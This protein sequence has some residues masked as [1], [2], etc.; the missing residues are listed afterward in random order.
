M[1]SITGHNWEVI[2]GNARQSLQSIPSDSVQCCVT[3]PP[4]FGQRDYSTAHQVWGGDLFCDHEWGDEIKIDTR[5]LQTDASGIQKYP[6][7]L[8]GP[9]WPD[10]RGKAR[11]NFCRCG[12][13]QGEFGT[14]PTPQLYTEHLVEIFREVR[15]VLRPDG[16]VFLN[17]GDSYATDNGGKHKSG[18]QGT[19]KGSLSDVPRNNYSASGI[20]RKNLIGIPWMAAFALRNDGW[21][22]RSEICW[23]KKNSMPES[24]TDRPS[25]AHEH[26]FMLTKSAKYYYDLVAVAEPA[27]CR[28]PGNQNHKGKAAYEGGDEKH[29]T[30]A[31]LSDVPA[32]ETRN[33]RSVWSLS[34]EP[35]KGAHFAV[36]PSEIPRRAI[37]SATSEGGCCSS[38]GTPYQRLIKKTRVPT[39]PGN[40]SKVNRASDKEAS[41][42]NGHNG[43]VVGNR[44]PRRHVTRTETIGWKSGCKCVDETGNPHPPVP[45]VVLDIFSGSGTSGM[46]ANE[47]G[48]RYIGLELNPEYAE[49][50]RE[51]I[52]SWKYKKI[53]KS[54]GK[55]SNKAKPTAGT[56]SRQ[57]FLDFA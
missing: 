51:R 53:K 22:L 40:D 11:G 28:T 20:P 21:I 25:R 31:G 10:L 57:K 30:K 45:C 50:S 42:Y 4:Y 55:S 19:N 39:R 54:K 43:D 8:V 37:K 18:I 36:F 34:S 27:T 15:R 1:P 29:R 17:L 46:V 48:R 6:G 33:L 9:Q 52:E 38:C 49:M 26:I 35:Y 7:T 41:P 2:I 13:W 23:H 56:K 44:D 5:G 12:A 14:E 47:L 3:S 16:C 24:V 32:G